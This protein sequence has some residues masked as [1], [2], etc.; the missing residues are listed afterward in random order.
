VPALHTLEAWRGAELSDR[1]ALEPR[2]ESQDKPALTQ[3]TQARA[4][5]CT[6]PSRNTPACPPFL[7]FQDDRDFTILFLLNHVSLPPLFLNP[8]KLGKMTSVAIPRGTTKGKH[9]PI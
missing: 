8:A 6:V 7:F 4:A 5:A 1:K 3:Q 9:T 2:K